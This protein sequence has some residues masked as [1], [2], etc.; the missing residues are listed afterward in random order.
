MSVKRAAA[1]IVLAIAA[2]AIVSSFG[3]ASAIAG[4]NSSPSA[5]ASRKG[6]SVKVRETRYGR[7]LFSAGG[8]A[9]YLFAK[10]Q[11]SKSR[12]YGACARAWPPVL[13]RGTPRARAGVDASKLGTTKR[14]DGKTQVTYNGHPLY[15]YVHD[16]VNQVGCQDVAEFGGKWYVVSPGGSAIT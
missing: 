2:T 4:L 16:S 7:I 14:R 10:E 5:E 15:Y 3:G 6:V 12:C 11:G 1:P 8:R 9:I 13:T